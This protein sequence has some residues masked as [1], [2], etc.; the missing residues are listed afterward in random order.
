MKKFFAVIMA[1]ILIKKVFHM[2]LYYASKFY[3]AL[4][5]GGRKI[6]SEINL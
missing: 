4:V 6:R 3:Y 1:M 2:A 5:D